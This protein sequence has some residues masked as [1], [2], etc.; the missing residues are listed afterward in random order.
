MPISE[1]MLDGEIDSIATDT[2][3]TVCLVS[4]CTQ[5]V[6]DLDLKFGVR[7]ATGICA[8]LKSP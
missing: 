1:W 3:L 5:G 4:L 2:D 6:A 8:G 7:I